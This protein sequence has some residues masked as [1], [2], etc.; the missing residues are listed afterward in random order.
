MIVTEGVTI[1]AI[2]LDE[3]PYQVCVEG[4][5]GKHQIC[6]IEAFWIKTE[7]PTRTEGPALADTFTFR[8]LGFDKTGNEAEGRYDGTMQGM[9]PAI[10]RRPDGSFGRYALRKLNDNLKANA[11]VIPAGFDR[12]GS[13]G[14]I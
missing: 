2:K 11:A 9:G 7:P 14:E 8:V 12:G 3:K 1:L 6:D 10:P 4:P 13:H 5:D